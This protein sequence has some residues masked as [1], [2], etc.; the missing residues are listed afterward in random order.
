MRKERENIREKAFMILI[1]KIHNPPSLLFWRRRT[2]PLRD[3]NQ[4]KER[5]AETEKEGKI[6]E[7]N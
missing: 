1:A 4:K 2:F 6:V 5:D 3:N 7:D